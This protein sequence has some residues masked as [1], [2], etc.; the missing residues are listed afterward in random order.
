MRYH[1][2]IFLGLILSLLAG[3]ARAQTTTP[4]TD[5]TQ[6]RHYTYIERVPVFPG[7]ESSDSTRSTS[8]RFMKFLNDGLIFPLRALRD[9]VNGRVFFSFTVNAQGRTTDIKL[10]KGLR[11]DVD[12]EVIRIA[13][14]L[15]AIQW[16]PGTQNG[17]PVSVAFAVPISF[18]TGDEARQALA[19]TG[20]SLEVPAF[21]RLALP[22]SAW[23]TDR[24]IFPT[25][26]GLVYGSCI[27]R[28]GFESGGLGQYVRL[29]NLTTG[30]SV[31]IEVKPPFRTRKQNDFCFALPPGRYALY[32]YGFTASKWY[33]GL[34]HEENLRKAP[35]SEPA[36]GHL[37][38]TRYLFTVAAG[39]LHYLGTWNLEQENAPVFLN[40]KAQLDA[41]LLP[42]FKNLSFGTAMV[43]LPQ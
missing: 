26:R 12:A 27:Q 16:K 4:A 43:A 28:L 31:R 18:A 7:Q 17:R 3:S 36:A 22:A 15:D 29:V 1:S 30:K 5:I 38:A 6:P 24:R 10:I 33:G 41:Q 37:S 8:Q 32:K 42:L 9:G 39:Q 19:A 34:L 14:R 11:E 25:D 21:N 13:H 23:G 2:T 40:E 35:N 20:D